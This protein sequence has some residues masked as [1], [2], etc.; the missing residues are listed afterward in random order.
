MKI[1][2][3][4][5]IDE[6]VVVQRGQK[7]VALVYATDQ[8]L[9]DKGM[10]RNEFNAKLNDY[11]RTINASLPKFCQLSALEVQSEEFS[12]TPKRNIKRYL[13]K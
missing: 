2:S 3:T 9:A 4:T 13:Y 1:T 7:L 12:K 10:S 6:T 8:T 5:I 11:R